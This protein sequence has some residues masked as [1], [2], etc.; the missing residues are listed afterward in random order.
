MKKFT[1]LVFV[2]TIFITFPSYSN[3]SSQ[4]ISSNKTRK[5]FELTDTNSDGLLSKSEMMAAQ[6]DRI[7]KLFIK[8]DKNGDSKLSRKE[9]R[10][11]RKQMKKRIIKLKN[12]GE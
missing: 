10:A 6:K 3:P 1:F 8:F 2:L 9:L 7:D 11:V 12:D 5:R 4:E